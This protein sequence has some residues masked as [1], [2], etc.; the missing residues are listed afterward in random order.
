MFGAKTTK[1]S[2]V[3]PKLG[4]R[5][6][7]TLEHAERLLL[8]PNNGGWMLAKDSKFELTKDGLKYRANT[9]GDKG[10]PKRSSSEQG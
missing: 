2:L 3:V 5:R 10:K 8:M 1:V 4:I 6:D 9:E 7:F